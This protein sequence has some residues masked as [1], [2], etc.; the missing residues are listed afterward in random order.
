MSPA[1]SECA[2][3]LLRKVPGTNRFVH[4]GAVH[5]IRERERIQAE[6]SGDKYVAS[7]HEMFAVNRHQIRHFLQM[8]NY[9]PT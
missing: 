9:K 2:R 5:S 7:R 1:S 3:D 8:G 6:E 4:R